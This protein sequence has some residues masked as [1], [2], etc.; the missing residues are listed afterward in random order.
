MAFRRDFGVVRGLN[1]MSLGSVVANGKPRSG[2][3]ELSLLR[4]RTGQK[5]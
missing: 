5:R 1:A 2:A 4:G 3:R